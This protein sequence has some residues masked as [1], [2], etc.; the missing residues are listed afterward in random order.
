M[1]TDTEFRPGVHEF[2]GL[3]YANYHVLHRTLLQ[4]MPKEWQYKFVELMEELNQEFS[5]IKTAP[6]Y[7]VQAATEGHVSDY[8]TEDLEARFGITPSLPE[9]DMDEDPDGYDNWS[10]EVEWL[11][12]DGKPIHGSGRFL[13]PMEDPVPHYDR[14]RTYI[15][16]LSATESG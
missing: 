8:S 2:F 6:Y 11:D 9:P 1:S 14:G 15:E 13:V 3:T 16:P 5:H 10:Y 7:E 12:R 4:S